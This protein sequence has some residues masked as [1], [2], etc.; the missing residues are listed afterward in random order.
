MLGCV[1]GNVWV[2]FDVGTDGKVYD[3]RVVRSLLPDFDIEAIKTVCALGK[4]VPGAD[5]TNNPATVTL[6]V[7]ILFKIR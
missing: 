1:E 3:A 5:T 7:P 2:A 4:F 6:T